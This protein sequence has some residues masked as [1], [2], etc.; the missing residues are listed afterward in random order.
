MGRLLAVYYPA[1]GDPVC[2]EAS[3]TLYDARKQPR[4]EYHLYPKT[5]L[6][7]EHANAGDL[8]VVFRSS[9]RDDLCILVTERGGEM[10]KSLLATYFPTPTPALERFTFPNRHRCLDASSEQ[11][12]VLIDLALGLGFDLA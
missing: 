10:E 6:F 4:S 5:R 11:Q 9:S 7:L 1:D 2:E 3:Y 12:R 8:L